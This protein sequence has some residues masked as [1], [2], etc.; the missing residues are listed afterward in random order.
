MVGDKSAAVRSAGRSSPRQRRAG[1]VAACLCTR[2]CN[3]VFMACRRHR[4]RH[5]SHSR[6]TLYR[7]ARMSDQPLTQ[8]GDH[9][10]THRHELQPGQV[11]RH[12]DGA[13][14][15]LDCRVP[16]DGTKWRVADWLNGWAYYD[17][18][19]EPGD[20]FGRTHRRH[21]CRD[22]ESRRRHRYQGAGRHR[23][24]KRPVPPSPNT[25]R[26]NLKYTNIL[27]AI[28]LASALTLAGCGASSHASP[29]TGAG[30][31][32]SGPNAISFLHQP[33]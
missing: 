24:P 12:L 30:A 32:V 13:F 7:A 26:S 9:W 18:E 10:Y 19:V 11:F 20:L 27:T 8:D 15:K 28:I 33:G 5:P 16:G 17:N 6:T 3:P 21:R 22:G 29:S 25:R 31:T 2:P 4:T 14:V 23:N 1:N